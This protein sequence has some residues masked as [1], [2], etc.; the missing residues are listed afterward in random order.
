[1]CIRDRFVFVQ[2]LVQVLVCFMFV[3]IQTNKYKYKQ[4]QINNTKPQSHTIIPVSYTHLLCSVQEWEALSMTNAL[5]TLLPIFEPSMYANTMLSSSTYTSRTNLKM[6]FS[7]GA[8]SY[9]HLDVY[10]RQI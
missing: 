7:L 10:K 8:V 9:T 5:P 3:H 1:M 6:S 4:I 2:V